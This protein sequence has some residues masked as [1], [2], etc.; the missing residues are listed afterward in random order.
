MNRNS[1]LDNKFMIDFQQTGNKMNERYNTRHNLNLMSPL[2]LK[3]TNLKITQ[4]DSFSVKPPL[5]K[6]SNHNIDKFSESL[7]MTDQR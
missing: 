3:D 4:P 1:P 5:S 6:I 7:H 2:G